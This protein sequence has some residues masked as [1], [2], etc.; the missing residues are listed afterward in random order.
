MARL[1]WYIAIASFL[2]VAVMAARLFPYASTS[3][4]KGQIALLSIGC[5][6]AAIYCGYK[7]RHW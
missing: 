1:L 5:V 2:Y 6:A 3:G 7:A 4:G